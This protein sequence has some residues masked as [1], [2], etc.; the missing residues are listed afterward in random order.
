MLKWKHGFLSLKQEKLSDEKGF[1]LVELLATLALF[2]VIIGLV[3]S[4]VMFGM[5]QYDRQTDSASQSNDYAYSMALLSKEIRKAEKVTI[6]EG[7]ITIDDNITYSQQ[8][9][10]LLGNDGQIIS[11]DV[12]EILFESINNNNI[13]I[14]LISNTGK[15][16]QTTI[17]LRR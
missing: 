17:H 9:T 1:T 12:K 6:S 11:D 13:S 10:Q 16:Y 14:K 4:V 3:G 15:E 5:K 2:S 7:S 8:G